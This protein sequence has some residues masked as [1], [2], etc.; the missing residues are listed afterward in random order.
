MPGGQ[1][2]NL[3]EQAASMGLS[4]QSGLPQG[5]RAGEFDPFAFAL[6][7]KAAN[8]DADEVLRLKQITG[9]AALFA[10][11]EFSNAWEPV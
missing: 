1:Y 5:T 9:L 6:L 4:A 8:M 7:K 11:R 3:K 10:D 2:T